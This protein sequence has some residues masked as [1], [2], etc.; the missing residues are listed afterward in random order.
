MILILPFDS[1]TSL[2]IRTRYFGSLKMFLVFLALYRYCQKSISG[3]LDLNFKVRCREFAMH[4]ALFVV[5]AVNFSSFC[6]K[7]FTA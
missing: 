6:H 2:P 5:I 1:A 3:V 4:S 7:K